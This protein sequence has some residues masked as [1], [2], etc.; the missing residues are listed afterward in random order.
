MG[1]WEPTYNTSKVTTRKKPL[2]V[3]PGGAQESK[4]VIS[5]PVAETLRVDDAGFPRIIAASHVYRVRQ[6]PHVGDRDDVALVEQKDLSL[7]DQLV[8]EL[9][10]V[11]ASSF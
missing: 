9:S 4:L 5:S 8:D 1:C 3:G 10:V 11:A 2:T 7:N 6:E